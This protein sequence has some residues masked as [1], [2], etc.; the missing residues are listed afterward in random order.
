MAAQ[1]HRQAESIIFLDTEYTAWLGSME[2]NWSA[3]GEYRELVQIGAVRV[4]HG[5]AEIETIDLLVKPVRN[6]L[7]SR[8]FVELTG[9]DQQR[10]ERDGLAFAVAWKRFS[11]FLLRY[12]AIVYSNGR[13]DHILAENL[14]LQ[15]MPAQLPDCEFRDIQPWIRQATGAPEFV[16][17][18][19]F[20]L[21]SGLE[22]SGQKHDALADA[23]SVAR[24]V[25]SLRSRGGPPLPHEQNQ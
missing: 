14:H 7:L 19:D 16:P 1:A 18:C 23:R 25:R 4:D 24:A 3:I 13:D 17:S 15:G 12:P 2:R 8:Y 9:I 10:L 21:A 11:E 20:P 5:L 22:Q 6:P